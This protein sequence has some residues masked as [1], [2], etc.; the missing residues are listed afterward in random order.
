MSSS[1]Q[2][3]DSSS[4]PSHKRPLWS[5]LLLWA[6]GVCAGLGVVVAILAWYAISVMEKN[7]PPLDALTDF[8]PKLPLRIYTSDHVLI[9][10]FGDEKRNVVRFKDIPPVMK[11]AVL[12][13]EDYRFYEHGGVDFT[14][15]ARALL[16]D[17]MHGGATQGA[18][19][20]TQQVARNFYLSNEKRL[21][22]KVYEMLL[23]YRIE[24]VLTKD[25][26][27]ELYMNQINLGEHAYGFASAERIYFGKDLKDITLAEAAMLA[28]I[29]KGPSTFNPIVNFPRAKVRQ[30]YILKRMLELKYIDEKQYEAAVHEP[31]R[32]AT[33][34]NQ[35]K[36]HGEYVAEMVRDALYSQYK[37]DIYTRGFS[38]ITTIKAADQ[39][40]AYEAVRS[41][42][43]DYD[44]RHGYRG[45][46]GF[47]TLPEDADERSQAIEDELD[48]HPAND[49]VV[50]AV[51]ISA[52]P[53]HVQ[54]VVQD[55]DTIEF[56]EAGL[57]FAAAALGPK[58][59]AGIRIR[60]GSVIR[61]MKD[62]K[63]NWQI[64]QIPQVEGALVSLQ[65]DDGA[66]H[67]LVGGFDFAKN[68]FNHVTQAWRQPGST[69]K[70]IIYS[71]ALEKGVGPSTLVND[72]PL[73]FPIEE[74]GGQVWDPKDDTTPIGPMPLR[75]GLAESRNLVAIRTLHFI[76]TQY[77]QEYATRFGFEADK[78]PPYLPMALGAGATTPLQ[79]AG[80]Y[81]VFANG[82]YRISPYLIGEIDDAKGTVMAKAKPVTI[83]TGAPRVIDERNA[84]V[85]ESLLKTVAQRG[86]GAGTNALKRTDLAGK[87][88][89]T[90]EARD[91]WFAG[92]QHTLVA[93]AWLGYDQPRSLGS[94][95]FGAQ[96]ALPVWVRYMD[97][98]LKN[99]PQYQTPMPDGVTVIDGELYFSDKTPGNGFVSGIDLPGGNSTDNAG[100][101]ATPTPGGDTPSA[102]PSPSGAPNP[103]AEKQQILD[104]FRSGKGQEK[105]AATPSP[106]TQGRQQI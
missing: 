84:Y 72:A 73:D 83:D 61:A 87:T 12:A 58:A 8:R 43:M 92:Y 106:A 10:E 97:K 68:K 42:V 46:E 21:T 9:G 81:A 54:A 53:K 102:A 98:A 31:L 16:A 95:E 45:P 50:A 20:I 41:S 27:L 5:R 48:D 77:A 28:G 59:S 4:T 66:I 35:Y 23:A 11:Q 55:G 103:S 51:V 65:P 63:G 29:P 38:V 52:T 33:G 91:G 75:T 82:G 19:T 93:V 25:Q 80:A 49:D 74:T 100:G 13:I 86:T 69:F 1:A 7:L 2:S 18:S 64:A 39:E 37:D 94:R 76:G 101:E 88:G 85:M 26:I 32:V 89:T 17:A 79:M 3:Q 70:P 105:P 34:T 22:R 78:T 90:N 44:R 96:L 71:A 57:K 40:A 60:P 47:I 67:A 36:V 24:S 104:L 56:N 14:G 15:I 30:E 99:V 6:L 62:A